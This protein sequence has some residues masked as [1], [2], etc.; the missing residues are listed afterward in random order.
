MSTD[1]LGTGP[2]PRRGPSLGVLADTG[3]HAVS[4]TPVALPTGAERLPD[5]P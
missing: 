4:E 1:L 2:G 5:E 3:R